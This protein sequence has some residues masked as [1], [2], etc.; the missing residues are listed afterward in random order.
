[1]EDVKETNDVT[2]VRNYKD[3][4]FRM[5]F[6]EKERLLSLYNA[7]NGTEYTD[8]DELEINTLENAIYLGRKNDI[9]FIIQNQMYLYEH[10]STLNP[11]MPL[12]NL[13]YVASLYTRMVDD[14]KLLSRKAFRLPKP[15]FVVFYNGTDKQPERLLLKLSELYEPG[16]GE[17]RIRITDEQP[18]L[19]LKTLVINI[20]RGYNEELKQSCRDLYG[21]MVYVDKVREYAK[22]YPLETAVEMAIN[23][24]IEHD[25]LSDFLRKRRAEVMSMSI[26]EYNQEAHLRQVAEENRA[27]GWEEGRKTGHR[28]GK[29]E[30]H[31]E[32]K[33]EGLREGKISGIIELLAELG[34]IPED[35]S[36]RIQSETD[37]TVLSGWNKLAAKCESIEDFITGM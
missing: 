6:S 8:P 16:S 29:I 24:C 14:E 3:S 26:F 11:N 33:R 25:I 5:L 31:R 12:R 17:N 13:F 28:E 23:Y 10:Q 7:L 2:P 36:L 27:D 20:N 30:G 22:R 15:Y 19:E 18:E 1:M 32:G 4:V 35:V 37:L 9:S 34:P 21:Y